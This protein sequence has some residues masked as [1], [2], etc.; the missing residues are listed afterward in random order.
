MHRNRAKS[1][2]LPC[3]TSCIRKSSGRTLFQWDTKSSEYFQCYDHI[4]GTPESRIVELC[5]YVISKFQQLM[6]SICK[7]LL[8]NLLCHYIIL[9]FFGIVIVIIFIFLFQII[10]TVLHLL[11]QYPFVYYKH[12]AVTSCLLFRR[13]FPAGV[14]LGK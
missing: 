14:S 11:S 5:N 10:S 3:T 2:S 8:I 7:R 13:L 6:F 4:H 9:N 12:A 1:C